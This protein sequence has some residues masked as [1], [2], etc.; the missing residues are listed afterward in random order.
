[1]TPKQLQDAILRASLEY[2]DGRGP[3][4][5]PDVYNALWLCDEKITKALNSAKR[6]R[7]SG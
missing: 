1:M 4:G 3:E 7:Y 6:S 5:V 2:L